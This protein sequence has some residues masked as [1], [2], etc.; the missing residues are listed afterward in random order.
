VYRALLDAEAVVGNAAQ[1]P[2][3]KAGADFSRASSVSRKRPN[4]SIS[5]PDAGSRTAA[6][7]AYP[8]FSATRIETLF[9]GSAYSSTRR[10]LTVFSRKQLRH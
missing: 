8:H 2:P 7:K 1:R 5:L 4:K 9:S 3:V 10:A 6:S